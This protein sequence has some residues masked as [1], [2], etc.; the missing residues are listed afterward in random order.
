M[1]KSGEPCSP[2][3][4][5]LG[6]SG[7]M[8]LAWSIT[9]P[10][11]QILISSLHCREACYLTVWSHNMKT[12][13]GICTAFIIVNGLFYFIYMYHIYCRYSLLYVGD[14]YNKE[15]NVLEAELTGYEV[16]GVALYVHF[17]WLILIFTLLEFY[18]AI[19][20]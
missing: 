2:N 15:Y 11:M 3:Y 9:T 20:I 5:S 13:S 8:Y 7:Y 1:I 6:C 19:N 16:S 10:C 14:Y 4:A 18:C 17:T 12:S